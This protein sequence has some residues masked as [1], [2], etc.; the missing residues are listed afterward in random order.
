MR[1]LSTP[2]TNHLEATRIL[3]HAQRGLIRIASEDA[4]PSASHRKKRKEN[5]FDHFRREYS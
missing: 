4:L 5:V 3:V 2:L 1:C